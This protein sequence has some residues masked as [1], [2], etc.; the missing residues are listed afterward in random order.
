[1]YAKAD[2]LLQAISYR[3]PLVKKGLNF[4]KEMNEYT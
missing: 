1:M 4:N 3:Q 2:L